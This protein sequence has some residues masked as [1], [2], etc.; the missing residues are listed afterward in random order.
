[1]DLAPREVAA[2]EPGGLPGRGLVPGGDAGK[3]HHPPC[4]GGGTNFP[5]GAAAGPQKSGVRA[6]GEPLAGSAGSPAREA[7]GDR[8]GAVVQPPPPESLPGETEIAVPA[9]SVLPAAL[10]DDSPGLSSGQ[11]AA[12]DGLSEGFL[13]SAQGAAAEGADPVDRRDGWR[14]QLAEA[15]E[16][17]RALFGVEAYNAWTSRAAAEALAERSRGD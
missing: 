10:L 2:T 11:A 17:Y 8:G 1:V 7:S 16:R 6:V 13:D 3:I 5:V 15:N 4:G 9:G 14:R 12:L